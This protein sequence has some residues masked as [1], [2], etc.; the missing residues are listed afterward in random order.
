MRTAPFTGAVMAG[1]ASRRM[2][3]DKALLSLDGEPLWLRQAR[4][5][6]EAGAITVGVVRQRE[7]TP[8][9]V[10]TGIALWHDAVGGA[11]PLAGLQ[12]ALGAGETERVAV[13]AVDMPRIDAGWFRWLLGF[14][15]PGGGALARHLNGG[16][17][18]LAA[19]YPCAALAEVT[20]R[21]TTGGERSLQSLVD[22]LIG[23]GLMTSVPLP[24]DDAWRVANWNTSAEVE[25]AGYGSKPTSSISA[26]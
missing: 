25:A 23:D 17:E 14:C 11:G 18:P 10:P 16:Y 19:I 5:L 6:R 7:Q 26:S 15:A 20:R 9:A 3:R 12:A 4:V 1:G 24:P 22:R 13:L 8:L 2:G 21:L